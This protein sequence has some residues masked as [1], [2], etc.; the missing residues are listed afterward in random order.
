M[1]VPGLHVGTE[2]ALGHGPV[3]PES[4]ADTVIDTWSC[5]TVWALTS[6]SAPAGLELVG[7]VLALESHELL[8]PLVDDLLVSQRLHDHF[9]IF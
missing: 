6:G 3:S 7:V 8:G 4:P 1:L 9:A 5:V 2:T